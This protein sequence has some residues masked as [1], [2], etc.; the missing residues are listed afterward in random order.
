MLRFTRPTVLAFVG[1][2]IASSA[3]SAPADVALREINPLLTNPRVTAPLDVHLAAIDRQIPSQRLLYVHLPGSCGA[4]QSSELISRHAAGLGFHVVTLSYP[5]CPSVDQL[6]N[7]SPD[8]DVHGQIRRERLYGVD[9]SPLVDVNPANSVRGRLIA[10]L[11]HLDEQFPSEGWRQYLDGAGLNWSRIVVGGHSQ[12]AGHA[13]YLSYDFPLAGALMFGGPGDVQDN[14][15]LAEWYSRPSVSGATIRVDFT[16]AQ[17]N[18]FPTTIRTCGVMGVSALGPIR[19]VDLARPPYRL[20]H[21]LTT[22]AEPATPGQY[23]G[24]VVVDRN[25]PLDESGAPVFAPVWTYMFNAALGRAGCETDFSGDGVVDP[26][27]LSDYIACYF[28]QCA[29]ADFDGSG[30]ID[31]DDLSDYIGAYFTGCRA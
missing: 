11:R 31:P 1:F 6:S 12:G 8:P 25:T 5:N 10:L 3:S 16:H 27:D 28:D 30:A 17:D 13:A 15:Q 18:L 19:N 4:P 14:G 24:S 23:H 29:G 26:D 22:L 2:A 21:Q 9:D 20:S 7:G